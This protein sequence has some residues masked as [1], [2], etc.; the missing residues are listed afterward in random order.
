[1][2]KIICT[3]GLLLCG[4]IAKSQEVSV[5][6]NMFN[7]QLGLI[8]ASFQYEAKLARKIALRVETGVSGNSYKVKVYS[9]GT[10]KDETGFITSPFLAVEPRLYYGLDRRSRLNKNTAHNSSNYISLRAIY[11]AN[12]WEISNSKQFYNV[13]PS[14]SILPYYGIRRTFAKH[15]NYEFNFGLGYQH[16]IIDSKVGCNCDTN[17]VAVDLQARIGY[18]F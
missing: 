2:R 8:S 13:V 16:N 10:T 4:V 15:F 12:D 11:F 17:E 7:V 5:D 6:K 3:V 14:I 9:A 1:M 18:T